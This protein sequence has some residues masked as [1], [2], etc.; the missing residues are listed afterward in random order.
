M[1]TRS[2]A[3]DALGIGQLRNAKAI[4]RPDLYG[5]GRAPAAAAA[6]TDVHQPKETP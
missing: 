5:R 1:A 2:E 3:Q 6:A 4:I